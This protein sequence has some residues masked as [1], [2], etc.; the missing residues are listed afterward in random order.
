MNV[1]Y[2]CAVPLKAKRGCSASLELGLHPA[3]SYPGVQNPGPPEEQPVLLTHEPCL[4]PLFCF[5]W[6]FKIVSHCVARLA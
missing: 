1:Y 5:V 3:V 2:V 4:Q 6:F